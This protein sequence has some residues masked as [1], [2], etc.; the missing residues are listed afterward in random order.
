[1]LE[2]SEVLTAI[3][4]M[5]VE[6]LPHLLGQLREIEASAM[7][8]LLG[9]QVPANGNSE[10]R[11]LTVEQAAERLGTTKDYLYRH[12]PKMTFARKYP[13]GLRFSESGLSAYIRRGQK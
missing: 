2:M 13:F 7:A 3:P 6:E 10:D 9:P 5:S 12:W 11:L 1:M 8:R 4:A